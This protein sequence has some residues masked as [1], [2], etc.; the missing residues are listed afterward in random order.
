MKIV[1]IHTHILY[2][3]DDGA[4]SIETAIEMLNNAVASDV[5]AVVLTPHCNH[6]AVERDNYATSDINERFKKL[7]EAAHDIPIDIYLGAE[8]HATKELPEL[9]DNGLI[10]TIGGTKYLLTEFMEDVQ[11]DYCDDMLKEITSRGL[12]PII[13]HP[14]RYHIICNAPRLVLDWLDLGCHLQLTAASITG[15][16]G[17][18][19][20]KTADF[21]LG[22]DLVCCVA[23]DAH[24]TKTRTN[25]LTDVHSYLSLYYS[26]QYAD[27]LLRY[28]PECICA[29]GIL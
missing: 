22:N 7:K 6:P 2:G 21:L 28:N 10:P 16:F 24:G 11:K 1:D 15:G 23:S 17:K 18:T 25:L 12:I 14:E 8:A 29:G 19:V 4:D 20:K 27:L 26:K 13:A 9:L 5:S 3:V